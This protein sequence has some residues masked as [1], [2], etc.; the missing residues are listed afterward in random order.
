MH[1]EL[2]LLDALVFVGAAW[3]LLGIPLLLTLDHLLNGMSARPVDSPLRAAWV[4]ET[5]GKIFP[6]GIDL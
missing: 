4:D 3:I 5:L 1:S 2:P 6:N